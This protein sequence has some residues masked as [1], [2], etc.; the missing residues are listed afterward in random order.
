MFSRVGD[1]SAEDPMHG[2]VYSP[3]VEPLSQPVAVVLGLHALRGRYTRTVET[4]RSNESPG[5]G[6]T[7]LNLNPIMDLASSYLYLLKQ[8]ATSSVWWLMSFL[9]FPRLSKTLFLAS[10]PLLLLSFARDLQVKLG[11]NSVEITLTFQVLH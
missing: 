6:G 5:K 4:C 8:Q 7:R 10:W 1:L 9:S 3:H 2:L 11:L